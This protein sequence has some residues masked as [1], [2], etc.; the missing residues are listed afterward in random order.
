MKH[1]IIYDEIIDAD[2]VEIVVEAPTLAQALDIASDHPSVYLPLDDLIGREC[3]SVE[4]AQK[5]ARHC[6]VYYIPYEN[7]REKE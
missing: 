6:M 4:R 1:W 2:T 3:Q 5:I 7:K